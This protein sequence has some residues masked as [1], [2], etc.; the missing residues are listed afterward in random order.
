[1]DS[2]SNSPK[3]ESDQPP[4]GRLLSRQLD[5]LEASFLRELFQSEGWRLLQ[6]GLSEM[7]QGHVNSLVAARDPVEV[8]RLQGRIGALEWA[9]NIR[10]VVFPAPRRGQ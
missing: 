8:Y 1:M 7:M 6:G 10:D 3:W 4:A 5:P 9:L 2:N